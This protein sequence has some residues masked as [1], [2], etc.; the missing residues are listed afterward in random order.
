M[1]D[2]GDAGLRPKRVGVVHERLPPERQPVSGGRLVRVLKAADERIGRFEAKS[3]THRPKLD[4]DGRTGLRRKG[5][6]QRP[7]FGLGLRG[8][9]AGKPAAGAFQQAGLRK[10]IVHAAA[11]NAA[12]ENAFGSGERIA[13]CR[14]CA[15][16]AIQASDAGFQGAAGD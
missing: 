11:S 14:D 2:G 9:R 8:V 10:L 1:G 4:R 3:R 12:D 5:S 15:I 7:Q 6:E 13:L 16:E